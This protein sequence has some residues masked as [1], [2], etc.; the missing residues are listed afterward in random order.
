MAPKSPEEKL[1]H[2][3]QRIAKLREQERK[4][5][6]AEAAAARKADTRRKVILGGLL[7]DAASKDANYSQVLD[8][9]LKRVDRDADKAAFTNWTPPTPEG[10]APR[11]TH[12]PK[13]PAQSTPSRSRPIQP[14]G[15]VPG[16]KANEK[17]R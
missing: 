10:P 7:L 6:A 14:L 16:M 1:E 11:P 15:F 3:Q 2:L 8:S 4:I 17:T 9:L 5:R 13:R 12:E